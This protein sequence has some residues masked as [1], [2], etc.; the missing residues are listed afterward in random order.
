MPDVYIDRTRW[1]KKPKHSKYRWIYTIEE[2]RA[3]KIKIV[4]EG[5]SKEE[6]VL[7]KKLNA[8]FRN[9]KWFSSNLRSEREDQAILKLIGYSEQKP[10]LYEHDPTHQRVPYTKKKATRV[11][12]KTPPTETVPEVFL[13][14][15][16]VYAEQIPSIKTLNTIFS[17]YGIL[18]VNDAPD[19]FEGTGNYVY[20]DNNNYNVSP[21]SKF[22]HEDLKDEELSAK[23]GTTV[24]ILL[25]HLSKVQLYEYLSAYRVAINTITPVQRYATYRLKT[26]RDKKTL[27]TRGDFE[28]VI[29]LHPAEEP[30][31]GMSPEFD[32]D[33]EI[34][35]D[36]EF[37]GGGKIKDYTG[38]VPQYRYKD[39]KVEDNKPA[40]RNEKDDPTRA[41]ITNEPKVSVCKKVMS[42]L[43]FLYTSD[44]KDPLL[45]A[46]RKLA[47]KSDI[48]VGITPCYS[49]MDVTNLPVGEDSLRAF[50]KGNNVKIEIKKR[51]VK[52]DPKLVSEYRAYALNFNACHPAKPVPESGVTLNRRD[53]M[54]LLKP[55][56]GTATEVELKPKKDK[57]RSSVCL[58]DK[59]IIA[60]IN[61][62]TES[63]LKYNVADK[64][65][66]RDSIY[67][68]S[69][70]DYST[71]VPKIN[72]EKM[73]A[74]WSNQMLTQL[75]NAY[76]LQCGNRQDMIRQ[77][78]NF[79]KFRNG[80]N[81]I[82]SQIVFARP[83]EKFVTPGDP[84][85]A[86]KSNIIINYLN[87]HYEGPKG[88]R[89]S[90]NKRFSRVNEITSMFKPSLRFTK[91]VLPDHETTAETELE[92]WQSPKAVTKEDIH[93]AD[94][95]VNPAAVVTKN[96]STR[97]DTTGKQ[98]LRDALEKARQNLS[99]AKNADMRAREKGRMTK[100]NLKA[101]HK[102]RS[103]KPEVV[104]AAKA[105]YDNALAANAADEAVAA[106][107]LKE[108][109]AAVMAARAA[110]KP[111]ALKPAAL[112]AVVDYN[113]DDAY[114]LPK[115]RRGGLRRRRT[116]KNI[117]SYYA[118]R[119]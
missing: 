83:L 15:I 67:I 66:P 3:K 8:Y 90:I 56:L 4:T 92:P 109:E 68:H 113:S 106:A 55:S 29:D 72:V 87:P 37:M 60:S 12:R 11:A 112:P 27:R 102:T 100:K 6:G 77:Y 74:F 114:T 75:M 54:Q 111:A 86:Y 97:S 50:V 52:I 18:V 80:D 16:V 36:G 78:D 40:K 46:E 93:V 84:C 58:N 43:K 71:G 26:T 76:S 79:M 107:K 41:D 51:N 25:L 31:S 105:A 110:L 115:T 81:G 85:R 91:K 94:R 95:A 64:L 14:E 99:A 70:F 2:L 116:R 73:Q 89:T 9:L 13:K 34:V 65:T 118:S 45:P 28:E 59:K 104:A 1:I 44:G 63:A 101:A 47:Y 48:V 42:L 119:R 7:L 62:T 21:D 103:K 69:L 61:K 53:R 49:A 32:Y 30:L 17:N 35:G 108:A 10:E 96:S 39:T 22:F 38:S 57:M 23:D 20:N 82:L 98:K 117:K 33:G 24:Q 19:M 88:D 5:L